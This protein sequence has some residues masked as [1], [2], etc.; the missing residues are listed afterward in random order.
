VNDLN[1]DIS[2]L[3]LQALPTTGDATTDLG[4]ASDLSVALCG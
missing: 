4:G 3:D 2:I 1:S